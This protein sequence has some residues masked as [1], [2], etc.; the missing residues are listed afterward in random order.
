MKESEV[1]DIFRKIFGRQRVHR[2]TPGP[3]SPRGVADCMVVYG[4][5]NFWVEIKINRTKLTALQKIFLRSVALPTVFH[6]DTKKKEITVF[7]DLDFD[8][9]VP[10]A[11]CGLTAQKAF[12]GWGYF[13]RDIK[14]IIEAEK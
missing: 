2:F 8:E 3:Y 5:R 13:A 7:R 9:F 10:F 1:I 12:K 4:D 11:G 14:A 6:V